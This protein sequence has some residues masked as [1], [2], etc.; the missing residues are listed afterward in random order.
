MLFLILDEVD[1]DGKEEADDGGRHA[2]ENDPPGVAGVD[3]AQR[4]RVGGRVT[5]EGGARTLA[6]ASGVCGE[7]NGFAGGGASKSLRDTCSHIGD[8]F[9]IDAD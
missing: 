8:Q 1:E 9:A 6:S 5:R 4:G 2:Q 7:E 3:P